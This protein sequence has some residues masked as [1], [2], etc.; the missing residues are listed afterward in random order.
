MRRGSRIG[1]TRESPAITQAIHGGYYKPG[2]RLPSE[3]ELADEYGVGRTTVREALIERLLGDI[4][5]EP[6][7]IARSGVGTTRLEYA[8][9]FMV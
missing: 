9:R 2:E 8:R 1:S 3:R 4:E 7:E 5:A 6:I